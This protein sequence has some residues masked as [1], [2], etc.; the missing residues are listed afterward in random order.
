VLV[1]GKTVAI[2][3]LNDDTSTLDFRTTTT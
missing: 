1:E 3:S 2:A